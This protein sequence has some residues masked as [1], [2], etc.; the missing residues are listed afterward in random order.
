MTTYSWTPLRE[1]HYPAAFAVS[2]PSNDPKQKKTLDFQTKLS[3]I[4]MKN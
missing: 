3:T 2:S 1:L 4:E